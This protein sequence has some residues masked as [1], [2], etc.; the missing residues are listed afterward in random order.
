MNAMSFL[1]CDWKNNTSNAHI[2]GIKIVSLK[3]SQFKN[4][5]QKDFACQKS[6]VP[7]L[8]LLPRGQ[9]Y[10]YTLF[11]HTRWANDLKQNVD[12]VF[13]NLFGT[14]S[15][16]KCIITEMQWCPTT[17]LDVLY[18]HGWTHWSIYNYTLWKKMINRLTFG[19]RIVNS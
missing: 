7:P 3:H 4:N 13:H 9:Y 19:N 16:I 2:K 18:K 14:C 10:R 5:E 6:R 12:F 17:P 11:T 8:P 15:E 1:L